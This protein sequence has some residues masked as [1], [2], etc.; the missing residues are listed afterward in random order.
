MSKVSDRPACLSSNSRLIAGTEPMVVEGNRVGVL[1][2]HGFTG[3]PWEVRPIAERLARS[4]RTIALPVL[5]GHGTHVDDLDA[6]SWNDW[7]DSAAQMLNAYHKRASCGAT[8]SIE[9]SDR[10]KL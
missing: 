9:M 10:L 3:S 2:L 4:G 5:A 1:I 8:F 6:T 7:L